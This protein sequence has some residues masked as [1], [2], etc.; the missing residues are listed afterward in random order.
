MVPVAL[1]AFHKPRFLG[2]GGTPGV[3]TIIPYVFSFTLLAIL[4]KT[5]AM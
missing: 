3:D 2:A 4:H 1:I 5:V